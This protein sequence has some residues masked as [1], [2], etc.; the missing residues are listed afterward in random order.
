MPGDPATKG[1]MF[2]SLKRSTYRLTGLFFLAFLTANIILVPA[3]VRANEPGVP[4]VDPAFAA[5]WQRIDLPVATQATQ[6]GWLWSRPVSTAFYEN[7]AGAAPFG[8][9][10]VQY[11]EKGRLETNY[12]GK[13]AVTSGLLVTELVTGQFQTGDSSYKKL[14]PSVVP[15]L[16]DNTN[17]TPTYA[18]LGEVWGKSTV[19]FEP[20]LPITAKWN[21]GKQEQYKADSATWLAQTQ[22]GFGIPRAFWYFMSGVG[23]VAENNQYTE[24]WLFDWRAYVGLP[25]TDAYWTQVK[26]GG[27][28]KDV[29]FQAFER[30][31]LT[32]TPSNPE[33]TQVESNNVG[34]HYVQ[35]RYDGKAP[36]PEHPLLPALDMSQTLPWYEITIENE[37][38]RSEPN[39]KAPVVPRTGSRPLLTAV[40][41][42]N[43]IQP[44]RTVKGEEVQPGNAN[45]FQL[46]EYPNMFVYSGYARRIEVPAFP[47][48]PRGHSGLWVAVS[49]EKQML[50]IFKDDK[51]VYRTLVATGKPGLDTPTGSFQI[52]GEF[53]PEVQ[54]MAGGWYRLEDIRYVSYFYRDFA[55]HGSYWTARYGQTRESFGC[56]NTT[57]YDAALVYQLPPGTWVEVF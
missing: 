13:A 43:T 6:R 8:R 50:A 56:V 46:Y 35:W 29:L 11:F 47:A 22:N 3:S 37:P 17:P 36:M 5:I 4:P 28:E 39:T 2:C 16:G 48:P 34:I 14:A 21:G 15:V 24:Q 1:R 49:L 54:V 27:V 7:Y 44:I 57:N 9:R 19:K 42:G 31:V 26:I 55:V 30:R 32:Y 25:M 51:P 33:A 52:D 38:L 53:R 23:V 41:K 10:L 40:S 12:P 45:W 20:D 18:Q